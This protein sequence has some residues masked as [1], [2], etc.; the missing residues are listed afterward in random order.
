PAEVFGKT[1]VFPTNDRQLE[2]I[3]LQRSAG[4]QTLGTLVLRIGGAAQRI[5][6]CRDRWQNGKAAWNRMVEQSASAS[7]AWTADNQLTAKLC[8]YETP[9]VVTLRLTFS[10]NEVQ[11]ASE[12]NV[13]FGATTEA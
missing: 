12:A 2:S 4:D 9:F 7:G 5:T 8:F 1:F 10:A 3:T 11:L 6:L 13:G